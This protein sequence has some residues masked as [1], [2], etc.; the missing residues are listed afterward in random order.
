MHELPSASANRTKHLT[1]REWQVVYLIVAAKPIKQIAAE[2]GIS[3][4]TVARYLAA[5]YAKLEVH[6]RA[7]LA[8]WGFRSGVREREAA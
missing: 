5:L 4:N 7:E 6:S 3:R 2:L 1:P 8:L